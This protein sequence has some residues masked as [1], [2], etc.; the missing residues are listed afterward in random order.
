LLKAEIGGDTFIS[1]PFII[2]QEPGIEVKYVCDQSVM[3]AWDKNSDAGSYNIYTMGEQYLEL[4]KSVIDT[5][6]ILDRAE[7]PSNYFAVEPVIEGNAGYRSAAYD[8]TTQGVNCYYKTFS[9]I[10]ENGN[11][12]LTL[13]LSTTFN[14]DHIIWQKEILN[15]FQAIGET[16]VTGA[17][18]VITFEDEELPAGVTV[19]RAVIFL[20]SD[21]RI[22]TNETIVYYADAVSFF[23]FPNPVERMSQDL[24]VLTDGSGLGIYFYD[25]TGRLVKR[26]K[27]LNSLFHF[28]VADLDPGL[29]LYRIQR[30]SQWVSSGKILLR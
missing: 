21:E 10:A 7:L 27:I 3:V 20:K 28:S 30:G 24:V 16:T 12:I 14:V 13:T 19:Y 6:A 9:A 26:Q 22:E 4:V 25:R 1:E 15:E 23:L 8:I 18:E 2:S 17:S 11:A 5:V 29:Y